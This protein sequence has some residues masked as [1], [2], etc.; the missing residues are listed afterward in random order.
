MTTIR[1]FTSTA[2]I[3]YSIVNVHFGTLNQFRSFMKAEPTVPFQYIYSVL[4]QEEGALP[5]SMYLVLYIAS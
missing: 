5:P 1:I 4:G 2:T 3:H